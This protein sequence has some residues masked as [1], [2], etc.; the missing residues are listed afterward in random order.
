[1]GDQTFFTLL[2]VQFCID[3]AWNIQFCIIKR[4]L[5]A[6]VFEKIALIT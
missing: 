6:V 3:Y 5:H 2:G 1:M 4:K